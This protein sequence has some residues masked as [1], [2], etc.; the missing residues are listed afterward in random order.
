MTRDPFL[1]RPGNL[2][3]PKSDFEIKI[4]RKVGCLQNANKVHF[5]SSAYDLLYNIQSF[6]NSHLEWKTKQLNGPGNYRELRETGPRDKT[7]NMFSNIH[8]CYLLHIT[9]EF[10]SIKLICT[11]LYAVFSHV[12]KAYTAN[13]N[14]VQ[15][16]HM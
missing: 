3:G 11:N 4:S 14:C 12:R 16:F 15:L 8:I 10:Y 7:Y 1:E 13:Q 2:T 5:V 9:R 6:S